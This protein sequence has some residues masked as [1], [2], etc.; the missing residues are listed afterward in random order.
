[1]FLFMKPPFQY[2]FFLIFISLARRPASTESLEYSVVGHRTV[3]ST[4]DGHWI[5]FVLLL[6]KGL[7]CRAFEKSKFLPFL[8]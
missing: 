6:F 3:A 2:F 1:M 5:Y 7:Y 4:V 8:F